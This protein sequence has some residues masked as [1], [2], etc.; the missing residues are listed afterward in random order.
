MRIENR[1]GMPLAIALAAA[2]ATGLGWASTVRADGYRLHHTI[3]RTVDAYDFTTGG[4]FM[5]PPVPYG[6]Y[7]KNHL[8]NPNYLIGCASCRLHA[9]MGGV[10]GIGHGH[11]GGLGTGCSACGGKGCGLCSGSGLGSGSGSGL[12]GHHGSG[13][14]C[15]VSGCAGGIGCGHHK[16]AGR[17]APIDAAGSACVGCGPV[18]TSNQSAP[19]AT[20]VVQPSSQYPCG[21][22]GCGVIG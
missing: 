14:A 3:P 13:S 6:H 5:A 15:D 9:L 11:G 20:T 12:F 4:E 8:Y 10:A 16:S 17:F 18:L 1:R 2:I 19:V 7:A 21:Q 22:A